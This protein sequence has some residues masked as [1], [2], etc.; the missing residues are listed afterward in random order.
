MKVEGIREIVQQIKILEGTLAWA[1]AKG[2]GTS[3]RAK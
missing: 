2:N 1:V 3:P